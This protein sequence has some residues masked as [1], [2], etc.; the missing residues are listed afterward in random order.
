MN[1][2][3]KKTIKVA[4]AHY[5]EDLFWLE[6]I[7]YES[8]IISKNGLP[9]EVSPN[10]GK[11]ASSY[12]EYIIKNYYKLPDIT[13]F[14]HGHRNS[15]HHPENVDETINKIIFNYNYYNINSVCS[16]RH[17]TKLLSLNEEG[18]SYLYP[19][20]Y[21]IENKIKFNI[22]PSRIKFRPAACFYVSKKAILQHRIDTY[23]YWLDWLMT[24]PEHSEI[25]SRVFEYCWHIIFTGSHVDRY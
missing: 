12:L 16:P 19:N 23:K 5:G 7:K 17:G 22:D 6:H 15:W 11:E 14:F 10:R 2:S 18:Q 13:I 8:Q 3:F 25:S 9:E 20:K 24:T 1:H 21:I 4:I